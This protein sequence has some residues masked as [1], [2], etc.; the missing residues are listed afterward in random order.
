MAS[1]QHQFW[2]ILGEDQ[3]FLDAYTATHT[4]A[5][6]T[7]DDAD[8]APE[9]PAAEHPSWHV[10]VAEEV[11]PVDRNAEWLEGLVYVRGYHY[12]HAG[13]KLLRAGLV[14]LQKK[15]AG[16]QRA[17]DAAGRTVVLDDPST[18]E[19]VVQLGTPKL[20]PPTWEQPEELRQQWLTVPYH[21]T[22]AE[23]WP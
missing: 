22:F 21:K 8:D 4:A 12:E 18:N 19:V 10:G 5:S 2:A 15:F 11:D 14:Y 23:D 1:L 13:Y 3:T 7:G 6:V 20:G 17:A 16:L 9:P